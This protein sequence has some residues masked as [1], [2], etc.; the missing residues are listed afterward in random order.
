MTK[1]EQLTDFEQLLLKQQWQLLQSGYSCKQIKI[2]RNSLI[3]DNVV[4]AKVLENKLVFLSTIPEARS[5]TT[6]TAT[7][8]PAPTS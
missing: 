2:C 5:I 1:Q 6:T 7:P 4:F 3:V 8:N